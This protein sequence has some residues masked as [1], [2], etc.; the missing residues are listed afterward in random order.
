[1]SRNRG[2]K[3]KEIRDLAFLDFRVFGCF[4]PILTR[5]SFKNQ[6]TNP[7][8]PFEQLFFQ[9]RNLFLWWRKVPE[10]LKTQK[11]CFHAKT[12]EI[13]VNTKKVYACMMASYL[14]GAQ[15]LRL[16]FREIVKLPRGLK[17]FPVNWETRFAKRQTLPQ[18]VWRIRNIQTIKS[19][20]LRG[21]KFDMR[22]LFLT[23]IW[24]TLEFC[25]IQ[26]SLETRFSQPLMHVFF[27]KNMSR[28]VRS[29]Y[30]WPRKG[31]FWKKLGV[32]KSGLQVERNRG[33]GVFGRFG[34]SELTQKK[35]HVK[36]FLVFPAS[37]FFMLPVAI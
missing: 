31:F 24:T 34:K 12:T 36:N 26:G 5:F 37:F 16:S 25:K 15:A 6:V 8:A 18:N 35:F 22:K 13:R 11:T 4:W 2:C 28:K 17:T 20:I 33:F 19:S 3:L 30:V 7:T 21:V 1:M 23:R 9:T 32:E 14:Q 10:A 27:W 29:N